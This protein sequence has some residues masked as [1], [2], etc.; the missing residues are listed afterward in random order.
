MFCRIGCQDLRL[1][2]PLHKRAHTSTRLGHGQRRVV[3][4]V[5]FGVEPKQPLA[6]VERALCASA[7]MLNLARQ[8]SSIVIAFG[9]FLRAF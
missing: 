8:I 5:Q 6:L 7:R 3:M 9:K 2:K 1:N 4:I